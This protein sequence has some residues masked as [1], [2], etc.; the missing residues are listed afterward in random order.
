MSLESET[1]TEVKSRFL[2]E[3]ASP[4]PTSADGIADAM[5]DVIAGVAI[6]TWD[7]VVK[8]AD[9]TKVSDTTLADDAVLKFAMAANAKYAFRARIFWTASAANGFKWR[10]NGPSSPSFLALKRGVILPGGSSETVAVDIAYSTADLATAGGAGTGTID[11]QGVLHNGA[12]VGN[13]AFQWAQSAAD[14]GGTIVRA[15]SYIEFRKVA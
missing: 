15:G 3:F 10:H 9:E 6:A 7:R 5:G 13:F 14:P 2:T 12:N 1:K 4:P 11:I 8:T